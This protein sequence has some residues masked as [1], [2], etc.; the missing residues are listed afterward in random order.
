ML[1][2]W[3]ND[4][5]AETDILDVLES[6]RRRNSRG[7]SVH[8]VFIS[9]M[10]PIIKVSREIFIHALPSFTDG[11]I[12]CPNQ[13]ARARHGMVLTWGARCVFGEHACS[14]H[15]SHRAIANNM[16]PVRAGIDFP[17]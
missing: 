6:S 2:R 15:L 3:H 11:N 5:D 8:A 7:R 16:S 1:D 12:L 4:T 13:Q 17:I 9:T 14:E 10:L